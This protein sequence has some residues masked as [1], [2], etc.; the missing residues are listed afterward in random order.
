MIDYAFISLGML[1]FAILMYVI[2]DGFDLGVGILY[3]FFDPQEQD[4]A[5]NSIA[6]MWDGNETWLVLGGMLLYA[7]FPKA[8]SVLMPALY[9]PLMTMLCALV[10]RGVAFEF[11]AKA[12]RHRHAWA[13]LFFGS[14]LLATFCQGALLG[15]IIEFSAKTIDLTQS[16]GL[17]WFSPFV[18]FCGIGLCFGYALLGAG[19]LVMKTRGTLY[20]KA[21]T[22]SFHLYIAAG[23]VLLATTIITPW[24]NPYISKLWFSNAFFYLMPLPILSIIVLSYAA[25]QTLQGHDSWPFLGGVFMFLTCFIGLAYSIYPYLLPMTPYYELAAHPKSLKLIVSVSSVLL[26]LLISYSAYAY[27]VF[28][29]KVESSV[30]YDK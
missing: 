8:Y 30:G 26:P 7:C 23:I 16:T 20:E 18:L 3:P 27:W 17:L 12:N 25:Y 10:G 24:V 13:R 15:T 1:A 14:S 9:A 22:L 21:Q 29:G 2:L 6:P 5:I 4:D 11:R 28:R 19:W